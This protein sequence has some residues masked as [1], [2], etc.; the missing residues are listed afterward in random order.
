MKFIKNLLF[1]F[2]FVLLSSTHGYTQQKT[3]KNN[4][5]KLIGAAKEI[6]QSAKTCALVT[7][8]DKGRPRIRTMDPFSPEE[9]L[10]VWLG[11]NSSSRKVIQI[12]NDNR[13]TLYYADKDDTGYVMIH[14]IASIVNDVAEKE[15]H[16]K[17]EWEEFY[18]N[19]PKDYLLIKVSPEWMEI[20]STSRNILGDSK[21]WEPQRVTF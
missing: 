11:T 4:D 7:I 12:K 20:L 1:T 15:E 6:M 18:P 5:S 21:T 19:Y 14:G 8:D 2:S 13:V 10:T 16:W 17:K 9:D 3:T